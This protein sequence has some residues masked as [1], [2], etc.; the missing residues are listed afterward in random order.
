MKRKVWGA[1]AVSVLFAGAAMAQLPEGY[2]DDLIV[3]VKPE[4]RAEFDAA[5][6]KMAD[7]NRRNQGA[8]WVAM[9]TVY[10]ENDTV[11]FIS[12]H[13]SYAEIEKARQ[14][15]LGA[16]IKAFGQAGAA[17]LF[18]DSADATASSRGRVRRRRW[19]LSVD[20]PAN[21]AA[22]LKLVGEARWVR[23]IA[24]HVRPGHTP[25]FE[26]LLKEIKAAREKSSTPLTTLVSVSDSGD[27][28]NVYYISRLLKSLG[29]LDGVSPLS[30]ILGE[31]GYKKYLK[32]SAETVGGTETYIN[33]FLPELSNPPAE[34][35]AAAPDFWIP[36]PKAAPKPKA[37]PAESAKPAGDAKQ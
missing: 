8:T 3:Q 26:E 28:G 33:R 18:H 12:T 9:E 27:H 5:V 15:F 2:L 1:L 23:T 19:D 6:K 29:D 22:L 11:S 37:K 32:I 14:A 4:K 24:V 7:A 36:K 21:P 13:A 35:A 20:P 34:Q 25:A 30:Q 16:L 31:E 10:G 17:K